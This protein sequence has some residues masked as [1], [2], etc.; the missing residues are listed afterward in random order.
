MVAGDHSALRIG[1]A[2][3]SYPDWRGTVYPQTAGSRFDALRYLAAYFDTIEI[4]SSFYRPPSPAT[5]ARWTETVADLPAFEFTAKL[6]RGFTHTEPAQWDTADVIAFR[7]G[8][9]PM[10]RAGKL[11]AVLAQFPF[12]F[13]ADETGLEHLRAIRAA[14]PELPLVVE[15]RHR[16]FLAPSAMNLLRSLCLSF[17]N[18]DQ[19]PS[20]SAIEPQ[21]RVTGPIGYLRLH[22]RNAAAWFS[23][24]AGRDEKFDYL[25]SRDQLAGFLPIIEA[26]ER[27]TARVY[28]VT[29]NHF[30]G[31]APANALELRG[32][33]HGAPVEVPADLLRTYPRLRTIAEDQ[34][35]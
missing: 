5:T 30:R 14:F 33:L 13:Q 31:Q 22:G 29:N 7:E 6:Y 3:W 2:G 28:V 12:H 27:T 34:A 9:S 1:P 11:G 25:Y 8:F 20:A 17:C 21:A 26:L 18:I 35:Q 4:N 10:I 16:S 32:L 24:A 19:P 23:K 15:V